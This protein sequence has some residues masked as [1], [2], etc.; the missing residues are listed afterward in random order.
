MSE[1]PSQ[2]PEVLEWFDQHHRALFQFACRLTGSAADAEEIVQDVFLGLLHRNRYQSDRAPV[3]TYLLGAV[4]NQAF[5][6]LR[7][8]E[9]PR[10]DSPEPASLETPEGIQ[11]SRQVSD[12]IAAA[13]ALLPV[14]QREVLLLSHYEQMPQA[15]IA[16][17]L[18][19]EVD[20][21]RARLYRARLSLKELLAPFAPTSTKEHAQ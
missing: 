9:D 3:R 15:E 14:A 5:K 19:I 1:H 20:A 11:Q 17:L 7:R 10:A 4:R 21:V 8:R 16:A 6:R 2:Q 12:A 13:V 18:G